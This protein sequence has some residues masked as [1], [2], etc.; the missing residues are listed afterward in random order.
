LDDPSGIQKN[1]RQGFFYTPRRARDIS[2][3]DDDM[4]VDKKWPLQFLTGI[5]FIS[6]KTKK[7]LFSLKSNPTIFKK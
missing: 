3:G 6:E 1:F 5:D 2:K 7:A 4:G